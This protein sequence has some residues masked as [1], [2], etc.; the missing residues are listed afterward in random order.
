MLTK[1]KIKFLLS[2]QQKKYRQLNNRFIVDGDKTVRELFN[3]PLK[4]E[5]LYAEPWWLWKNKHIYSDGVEIV[6]V[7]EKEL[8][9]ISTLEA[10]T[11]VLAVAQI[12]TE[13]KPKLERGK[14][15]LALDDINDPGNFGTIIRIAEWFGVETIFCSEHC[16]DAYNP[17]VVSAAK[18]S[19][20]RTKL[21]YG[22]LPQ[23]FEK[24]KAPVFGTILNGNNIYK[25]DL[26]HEG[27]VLI[28]NE[29]HGVSSELLPFLKLKLSIPG[30]GNA[31]SLNAG[32]ATGIILS[33]FYRRK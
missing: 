19:L 5:T 23:L 22:S 18:G 29:A 25:A 24:S 13:D 20:F 31:E 28:G 10:P 8:Q 7:S 30:S 21:F 12:P 15:T 26:P 32:V 17:K 27:I 14:I 2:L 11:G 1:S 6:E 3:S 33:E 16:V 9:Q 4:V